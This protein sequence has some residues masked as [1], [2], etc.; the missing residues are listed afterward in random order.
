MIAENYYS[1]GATAAAGG[2]TTAG[3]Q[4][5]NL[6]CI[7]S[8]IRDDGPSTAADVRPPHDVRPGN[9]PAEDL[10]EMPVNEVPEPVVRRQRVRVFPGMAVLSKV[11][12]VLMLL[13][14]MAGTVMLASGRYP[15]GVTLPAC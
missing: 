4:N 1:N 11:A 12:A 15:S 5:R 7:V 9:C 6:S 13:A 14:F 10:P 2:G 8:T 3:R